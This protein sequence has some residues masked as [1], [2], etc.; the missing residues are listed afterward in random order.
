MDQ[1]ANLVPK[2][3]MPTGTLEIPGLGSQTVV[4]EGP[5]LAAD[6]RGRML[7]T[8]VPAVRGSYE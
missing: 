4:G 8:L 7:G 1:E 6:Q 2:V 5:G 3:P